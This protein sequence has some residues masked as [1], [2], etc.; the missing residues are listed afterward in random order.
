MLRSLLTDPAILL[1]LG[2][3][4]VL[5]LLLLLEL[6][7][8]HK[9]ARTKRLEEERNAEF[10][11]VPPSHASRPKGSVKAARRNS[12]QD[13]Y[14]R[15]PAPPNDDDDI[16]PDIIAEAET[17]RMRRKTAPPPE[18]GSDDSSGKVRGFDDERTDKRSA[19]LP[20]P[21]E[22]IDV[23]RPDSDYLNDTGT[24]DDG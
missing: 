9:N 21:T 4:G 10:W 5:L 1:S 17:K 11:R 13:E 2:I 6:R 18:E 23:L 20:K 14:I 3:I 16:W 24:G 12:L 7:R 8:G 19:Y 22:V 15:L